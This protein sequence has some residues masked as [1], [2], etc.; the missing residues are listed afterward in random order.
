MGSSS[1]NSPLFVY[2]FIPLLFS[3]F[4][5][6]EAF[7]I[8][9][10]HNVP[11][12]FC[13][14]LCVKGR[15]RAHKQLCRMSHV[16]CIIYQSKRHFIA[17]IFLPLNCSERP[18]SF[19]HVYSLKKHIIALILLTSLL[20]NLRYFVPGLLAGGGALWACSRLPLSSRGWVPCNVAETARE[21]SVSMFASLWPV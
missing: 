13:V 11:R 2:L 16:F 5:A 3:V 15:M 10:V 17:H 18:Q 8:P 7:E 14:P 21:C 12:L 6:E 19:V 20:S 1:N 4:L 9:T